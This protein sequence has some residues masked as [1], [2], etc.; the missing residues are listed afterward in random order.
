[1]HR[2]LV[3]MQITITPWKRNL[4]G[5][6]SERAC[7]TVI[8]FIDLIDETHP[9][10]RKRGV[11]LFRRFIVGVIATPNHLQIFWKLGHRIK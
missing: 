3:A 11:V 9:T 7:R 2:S 8:P 10:S 1:M 6:V 4:S 5:K